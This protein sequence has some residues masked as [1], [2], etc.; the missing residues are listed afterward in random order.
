MA[1]RA[2]FALDHKAEPGRGEIP[3]A[4][5]GRAPGRKDVELLVKNMAVRAVVCIFLLVLAA[6]GEA[7]APAEIRIVG[8]RPSLAQPGAG[9]GQMLEQGQNVLGLMA[10]SFQQG[11]LDERLLHPEVVVVLDVTNKNALGATM[12]DLQGTFFCDN[13]PMGTIR[14]L[15]GARIAIPARGTIRMEGIVAVNGPEALEQLLAPRGTSFP[16]CRLSGTATLDTPLGVK[17]LPL[18]ETPAKTPHTS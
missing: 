15:P 14:L 7:F 13:R 6:C 1:S 2:R 5:A 11:R 18:P 3:G 10:Q 16:V 4:G 9:L 17:R 12:T 8:I